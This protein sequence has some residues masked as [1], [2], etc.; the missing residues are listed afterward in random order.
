MT[1]VHWINDLAKRGWYQPAVSS[2]SP[3]W[4]RT[5]VALAQEISALSECRPSVD[6]LARKLKASVRTVKYHLAHLRAAGLLV[7]RSKG[8]RIGG[9]VRLASHYERIIPAAF[10]DAFG[11]RTIQ[12]DEAAPAYTRVPVGA[13]PEHRKALGKLAKKATRKTRRRPLASFSRRR[14]CTPMQGGTSTSSPT[15]LSLVPSEK[16]SASGDQDSPTQQ[17]SKRGP[18]RGRKTLNK[19]GRRYQLARQLVAEVPWLA[20][21]PVAR[22]SWIVRHCA[23]TGWTAL[24]VRAAAEDAGPL[25]REDARRPVGMLAHRL[26]GAA[27]LFNTPARRKTVVDAWTDSRPQE[28]ARHD[29]YEAGIHTAAAPGSIASR[30]IANEAMA[31]IRKTIADRQ[32]ALAHAID[33][34]YP[35][36]NIDLASLSRDDIIEARMAASQDN[37]L[38]LAALETG[39]PERDVRRL[40]SNVLVD[41]ALNA[42][43]LTAAAMQ[44][45]F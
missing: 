36:T 24:E 1:A 9:G 29:G 6:Y 17:Q 10:D 22:I 5:T 42:R 27:N 45:A 15:S 38:I 7:Y 26:K 4:G 11:I 32:A 33:E 3:K 44:P 37:G 34:V 2:H 40:Y 19:V 31:H 35:D 16:S 20:G 30:R 12:R 14:R 8:T 13:A 23:D 39:V 41:R 43:R 25:T 28:R 18:S 21:A